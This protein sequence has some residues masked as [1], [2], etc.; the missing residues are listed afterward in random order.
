[1]DDLYGHGTHVAGIAAAATNNGLGV[2]GLGYNAT[3]MNVKVLGDQGSGYYSWIASCIT[4]SADNG[5]K[6]IE[7]AEHGIMKKWP[8][9]FQEAH[10]NW[11]S[12]ERLQDKYIKLAGEAASS[13]KDKEKNKVL[14]NLKETAELNEEIVAK[15]SS[16]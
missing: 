7:S 8:D 10:P 12:S 5:A 9:Q 14:D 11:T 16:N 2:A 15:H 3:L 1:M 6:V 4:W 13:L